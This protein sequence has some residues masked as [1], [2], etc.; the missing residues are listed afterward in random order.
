MNNKFEKPELNIILFVDDDI[1]VT[2]SHGS[3]PYGPIDD[4]SGFND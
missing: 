4:S 2:S 1:I 3:D